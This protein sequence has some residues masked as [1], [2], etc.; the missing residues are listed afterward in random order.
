M[1]REGKP[2]AELFKELMKSMHARACKKCAQG[3]LW[4][5]A[6]RTKARLWPSKA[7]ERRIKT[8]AAHRE[9][10]GMRRALG[11]LAAQ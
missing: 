2:A 5:G 8:V 9:H 3:S 7:C 6:N 4:K 11:A 10:Q 1:A